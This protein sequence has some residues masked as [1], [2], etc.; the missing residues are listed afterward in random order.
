MPSGYSAIGLDFN[1]LDGIAMYDVISMADVLEHMP[2][3]LQSLSRAHALLRPRGL[4]F[5]SMPNMD[6]ITWRL[7]R[8]S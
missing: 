5:L 7:L 1:R 3:P 2:H 8:H 4:L 6:A